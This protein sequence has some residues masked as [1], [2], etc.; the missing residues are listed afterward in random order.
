VPYIPQ[1]VRD[2][3][4]EELK[5]EVMQQAKQE[6]WAQPGAIP[7]WLDRVSVSGDVRV[8][9]QYNLYSRNNTNELIDF[10]TF[11]AA[12]PTDINP[13]TNP[14]GLPFLNT[15][16]GSSNVLSLRARLA[17]DAKL[18]DYVGAG[19]R[20]AT[21]DSNGAVSTTTLLGGGFAKN[22]IWLDRGFV[23]FKPAPW[24]AFTAGRMPDP[25]LTTDLL[26][27]DD[28][29][30][31]GATGK[32][33]KLLPRR[34]AT[35]SLVGGAFPLGYQGANFPTNSSEKNAARSD[36]LFAGQ[37]VLD[38]APAAFDLKTAVGFYDFENVRGVLS[39][40]CALYNGNKQCSTD[41][42]VPAIQQ[43]GNTL[44]FVRN[45]LPN[46]S[47]PLDYAEP[48]LLGLRF[49]YR[50]LDLTSQLDY[51]V[52]NFHHLVLTGQFV[53]NMAYNARDICRDAPNGLP[54]NNLT[55]SSLGNTDPCGAP[56]SGDT[57]AVFKSGPNAYL[58]R[59]LYGDV[60]PKRFGEWN[61]SFG[62]RRI[63]PDAMLDGFNS[64]D[65]HLGGTN[66]Q[67]YT[68]TATVGLYSGAYLQAR[69]FSA[70]AVYGPPL[71]I[72][73][74]QLDLHVRF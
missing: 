6:G 3:I 22:N 40:P 44:F 25:F 15:R 23:W 9:S 8:R 14:N 10:S 66:A 73:V 39:T 19:F 37:A 69:W 43:K 38:W 55:A 67:G 63:E 36:W 33:V 49:G 52:G 24:A 62:Y 58:V 74:G 47:S 56:P 48:Q 65:F 12:G 31:D 60:D 17:F 45:I 64:P 72:D 57:R 46:P 21:G 42:T 71:T 68:L 32:V 29:N 35:L 13:D 59:L 34:D 41:F 5:T 30:F 61:V 2:E 18:S 7:G 11:N 51:R 54:V 70:D 53:R 26:Y 4:R 1:V 50:L 16:Q 28:L 20:L 27:S